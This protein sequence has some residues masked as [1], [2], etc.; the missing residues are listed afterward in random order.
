M[1]PV[2]LQRPFDRELGTTLLPM[3]I[4]KG[5]AYSAGAL[6]MLP[7]IDDAIAMLLYGFTGSITS[8]GAGPGYTHILGGNDDS[9]PTKYMAFRRR[10]PKA[11]GTFYGE[12]LWDGRVMGITLRAQAGQMVGMQV[13]LQALEPIPTDNCSGA[14]WTPTTDQGGYEDYRRVPIATRALVTMPDGSFATLFRNLQI[15]M[16]LNAPRPEDEMVIG[17]YFPH[18][19]TPL[20]RDI[21]IAGQWFWQN[22]DLYQKIY[23]GGLSAWSAEPYVGSFAA[24]FETPGNCM[25][26]NTLTGLLGFTGYKVGWT[27]DPVDLVGNDLV[28]MNMQGTV[29]N[30]GSFEDWRIHLRNDT[31]TLVWPT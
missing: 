28:V 15:A 3:G 17:S 29:I 16:T 27:C 1:G 30:N 23:Y 11:G 9:I 14:G 25:A 10:I 2:Q 22:A 6:D 26:G 4:Y 20:S 5:G 24:E 18:D 21:T 7:R 19:I 12:T 8:T 31:A 13:N